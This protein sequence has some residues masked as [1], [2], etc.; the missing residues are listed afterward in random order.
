VSNKDRFLSLNGKHPLLI[1]ESRK[2]EW[3]LSKIELVSLNGKH[4][5]YYLDYIRKIHNVYSGVRIYLQIYFM[6][7]LF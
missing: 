6:D 1:I 5:S 4:P 3:C 2:I 7:A